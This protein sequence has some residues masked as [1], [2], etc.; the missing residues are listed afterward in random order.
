MKPALSLVLLA[1]LAAQPF[2]P[3]QAADAPGIRKVPVQFAKGA[4]SAQVRG[5]VK[6]DTTI[7]YTV[8]ARA[9][10]TL[11]VSMK[12]SNTALNFNINPPG[13]QTAMFNGSSQG[14][15]AKV[16]LPGDGTYSVRVYLMRSGARR[17]ESG[18]FTLDVGVSGQALPPLSGAQDAR[19]PGTPFH[20]TAQVPCKVLGAPPDAQC[21]ASVV[22]RG[23]DG[24]A[25]VELLS[26]NGVLRRVLFVK[27]QVVAS[28]AVDELKMTRQG[29]VNKV[30]IGNGYETYDIPDP[31]LTGG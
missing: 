14:S 4:S 22:R 12:S 24:T 13:T 19:V 21:K 1:A 31:L 17:N 29:D 25:T 16:M 27:G 23:R 9:G 10:Q 3:A 6:G 30:D 5:A 8:S 18:S 26:P 11:T 28:D 15:D 7:D 20:A 2:T